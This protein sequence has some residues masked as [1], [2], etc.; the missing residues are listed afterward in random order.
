MLGIRHLSKK[1]FLQSSL[2]L[3]FCLSF[4]ILSCRCFQFSPFFFVIHLLSFKLFFV[5][6]ALAVV[7]FGKIFLASK[8]NFLNSFCL[9]LLVG[10]LWQARAPLRFEPFR[11]FIRLSITILLP[12]PT[13]SLFSLPPFLCLLL[14]FFLSICLYLSVSRVAHMAQGLCVKTQRILYSLVALNSSR[15]KRENENWPTNGFFLF[16]VRFDSFFSFVRLQI[17]VAIT[18][19][20]NSFNLLPTANY[21]ITCTIIFKL[22]FLTFL[23]H[24]LF[25]TL[26]IIDIT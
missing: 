25:L 21:K 13:F 15:R 11:L 14:L 7:R 24:R 20:A 17:C 1:D 19:F 4:Y 5:L 16:F 8:N 3:P 9:H 18:N 12:F 10:I 26:L 6:F 2:S 22:D 23:T